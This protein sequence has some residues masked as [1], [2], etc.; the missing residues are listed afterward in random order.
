MGRALVVVT[1]VI[2]MALIAEVS[3]QDAPPAPPAPPDDARVHDMG[4]F[5][6]GR[7]PQR[8]MPERAVMQRINGHVLLECVVNDD[9]RV[10][11]CQVVEEE[12][13]GIGFSRSALTLACRH[14]QRRYGQPVDPRIPIFSRADGTSRVRMPMRFNVE[15][16]ATRN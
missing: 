11:S 4:R 13:S 5:C 1:A 16:A 3:A 15:G 8:V 6:P 12:P 14:S 2:A 10:T 7:M 9:R